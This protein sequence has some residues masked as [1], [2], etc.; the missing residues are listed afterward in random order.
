[1]LGPLACQAAFESA[2]A[3][4]YRAPVLAAPCY[5]RPFKLEVDASACGVGAVLLPE[6]DQAIDHSVCYFSKKSNKHQPNCT[7]IEMEALILLWPHSISK[8]ILGLVHS[9]ST[10][11]IYRPQPITVS[12]TNLQY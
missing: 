2:K 1:M 5:T 3:L 6:D 4:L 7:T 9:P 12:H 11:S 10:Y 8:F